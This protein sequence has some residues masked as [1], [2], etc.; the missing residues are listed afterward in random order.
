MQTVERLTFLNVLDA[1]AVG[2]LL[3]KHLEEPPLGSP[4]PGGGHL[5]G[6]SALAAPAAC[7]RHARSADAT[8][9]RAAHLFC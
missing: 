2:L 4:S 3:A 5:L 6:C 1:R 9:E 7:D 8:R